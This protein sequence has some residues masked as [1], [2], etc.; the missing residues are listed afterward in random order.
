MKPLDQMSAREAIHESYGV[1]MT[2]S[3]SAL[4]P[5]TTSG[6]KN[7]SNSLIAAGCEAGKLISVVESLPRHI[8]HWAVWAYGP[9]VERFEL[10]AQAGLF[11]WL[12][13][14]VDFVLDASGREYGESM[15]ERIR[16][17]VAYTV[18]NHRHFSNARKPLHPVS[19]IKKLCK[20]HHQ[21]WQRD[22]QPWKEWA[23]L[24]CADLD[25]LSL[26]VVSKLLALVAED[27]ETPDVIA[28]AM[29]KKAINYIKKINR[30]NYES[31]TV[32]S[33]V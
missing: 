13:D 2:V 25:R 31:E 19:E 12:S 1:Q 32:A 22:F 5:R 10:P 24:L 27:L 11:T 15:R 26:P 17:V 4:E 30:K 7:I 28:Q 6:T 8:R 16:S 14:Q 29:G 9:Q 33:G 21:S 18:I 3:Q 20:I 23:E